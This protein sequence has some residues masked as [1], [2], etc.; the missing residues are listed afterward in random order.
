MNKTVV[1][2]LFERINLWLPINDPLRMELESGIPSW[3]DK[4]KEQI[5]EAYVDGLEYGIH[6]HNKDAESYYTKKYGVQNE[7]LD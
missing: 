4:E 7:R 1:Q 5:M 6:E 2:E 3:L